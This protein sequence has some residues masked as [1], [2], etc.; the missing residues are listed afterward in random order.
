VCVPAIDIP[1]ARPLPG[2]VAAAV[3]PVC[4]RAHRHVPPSWFLTTSTVCSARQAS[5]LL[6]PEAE[7]GSLRFPTSPPRRRPKPPFVDRR[8]V[9]RNAV[10]TPRRI[11]LASSRT[12]SPWPLPSCRFCG[13]RA[14]ARRSARCDTRTCQQVAARHRRSPPERC[15]PRRAAPHSSLSPPDRDPGPPRGA[16]HLSGPAL[17]ATDPSSLSGRIRVHR[18]LLRRGAARA[19]WMP[20]H[21]RRDPPRRSRAESEPPTPDRELPG[22]PEPARAPVHSVVRRPAGACDSVPTHVRMWTRPGFATMTGT[23]L[24]KSAGQA[25]RPVPTNAGTWLPGFAASVPRGVPRRPKP[26]L[27]PQPRRASGH[28]APAVSQANLRSC[29]RSPLPVQP[30]SRPCSTD[31]SVASTA[32]ASRRRPILPWALFPFEVRSSPPP[33]QRRARGETMLRSSLRRFRDPGEPGALPSQSVRRVRWRRA[34]A[35]SEDLSPWLAADLPGVFN[36]KDR[37]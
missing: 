8:V 14:T 29:Q 36:V 4:C 24:S 1:V 2:S 9:P 5:G 7:R 10:H 37:V 12:T 15:P 17:T 27:H 31:E 22:R 34:G 19:V 26:V 18:P 11:P 21:P 28:G 20:K 13:A 23:L 3:R 6:R 16:T 25:T 32:V 35:G 30:T 33:V